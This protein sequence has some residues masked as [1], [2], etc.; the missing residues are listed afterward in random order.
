MILTKLT[1]RAHNCSLNHRTYSE[2]ATTQLCNK[3]QL[4]HQCIKKNHSKHGGATKLF[5]DFKNCDISHLH[6]KVGAQQDK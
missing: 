3:D 5:K 6:S 4:P 2:I 1:S